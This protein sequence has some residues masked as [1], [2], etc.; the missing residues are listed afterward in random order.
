MDGALVKTPYFYADQV[1]TTERC[2]LQPETHAV[3]RFWAA[4]PAPHVVDAFSAEA[5]AMC[6]AAEEG[7]CAS[8]EQFH[9]DSPSRA[10]V[11]RVACARGEEEQAV[12]R[13]RSMVDAARVALV[14]KML[15]FRALIEAEVPP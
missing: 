2:P 7:A 8:R 9:P 12:D 15:T 11:V 14:T 1:H 5:D 6:Q 13:A 4:A 3:V 10:L